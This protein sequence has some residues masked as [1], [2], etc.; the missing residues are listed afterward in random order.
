MDQD[1]THSD[2]RIPT[3]LARPEEYDPAPDSDRF[4]AKSMLGIMSVLE[5]FRLEGGQAG[6]FEPAPL[7]KLVALVATV[8]M[9]SLARNFAFVACVLALVLARMCM[10]P[11]NALRETTLTGLIA[12][13][14]TLLIMLP[15]I[16][17]GQTQAA[18]VLPVKVFACASLALIVSTTTPFNQL[19]ASLRQL[20]VPNVIIL[21]VDLTLKYIVMLGEVA[22]STLTALKCRSVGKDH[23]KSSSL[24]NV[25]GVAFVKSQEL[26]LETYAAMT[27]RGFTGE[28]AARVPQGASG[29]RALCTAASAL[30]LV[31]LACAFLLLEGVIPW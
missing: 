26:S 20:H 29:R 30:G 21:T 31:A 7:F 12:A 17:L 14:L 27:C 5:R 28:Y 13:S 1:H 23:D 11:S 2:A 10:L 3:W 25:V 22:L 24:G 18:V 8:L 4:L 19:T 15:A 16:L 9:V 6:R